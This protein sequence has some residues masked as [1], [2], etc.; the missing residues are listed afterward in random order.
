MRFYESLD[1]YKTYDSSLWG[2]WSPNEGEVAN[3]KEEGLVI[4]KGGE[5]NL[6]KDP[7]GELNP[8]HGYKCWPLHHYYRVLVEWGKILLALFFALFYFRFE[9]HLPVT[10][11]YVNLRVSETSI[12]TYLLL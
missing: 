3:F 7:C 2:S 1:F 10:T 6:K 4:P 8:G 12:K 9:I 11:Q 5:G